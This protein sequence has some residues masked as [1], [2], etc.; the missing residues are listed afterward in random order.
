MIKRFLCWIGIH[1]YR[2][3]DGPGF[4]PVHAVPGICTW[5]GHEH[6]R[7]SEPPGYQR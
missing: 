7:D 5:C 4:Y 2:L 1:H 6:E 3:K